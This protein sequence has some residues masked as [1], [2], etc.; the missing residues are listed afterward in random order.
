MRLSLSAS[1]FDCRDRD[2]AQHA[3]ELRDSKPEPEAPGRI[4][5]RDG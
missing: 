3:L 2:P 1:A 4:R 5:A